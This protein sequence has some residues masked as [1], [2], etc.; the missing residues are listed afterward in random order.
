MSKDEKPQ[1][2]A[3]YGGSKPPIKE[4]PDRRIVSGSKP[5]KPKEERKVPPAGPPAGKAGPSGGF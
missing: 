5:T 4:T 1:N 3:D 2:L